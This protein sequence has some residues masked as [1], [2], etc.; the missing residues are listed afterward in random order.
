MHYDN[1][2]E[3]MMIYV[4]QKINQRLIIKLGFK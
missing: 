1:I 4:L 2:D 3:I